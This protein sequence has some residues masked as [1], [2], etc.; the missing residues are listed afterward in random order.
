MTVH[1]LQPL[2][3][4]RGHSALEDLAPVL[5][6]ET[7]QIALGARRHRVRCRGGAGAITAGTTTARL[8]VERRLTPAQHLEP[9]YNHSNNNTHHVTK[10]YTRLK[11]YLG[12]T[13]RHS[14]AIT[15]VTAL[16]S[17][18]FHFIMF[19]HFLPSSSPIYLLPLYLFHFLVFV[20][21]HSLHI[22]DHVTCVASPRVKG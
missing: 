5:L 16:I 7:L 17:S 10:I 18:P 6:A 3:A 19:L 2:Q 8:R 13:L 22:T 14:N 9:Q 12:P 1:L 4:V 21:A 20:L 15:A 11:I